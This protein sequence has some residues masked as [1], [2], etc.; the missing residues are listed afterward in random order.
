MGN[1]DEAVPRVVVGVSGGPR[2]VATVRA[3]FGEAWRRGCQLHLVHVWEPGGDRVAPYAVPGPRPSLTGRCSEERLLNATE[4]AAVRLPGVACTVEVAT[5]LP[6]RVLID[7]AYGAD[8]L[9][10]GGRASDPAPET[11]ATIGP[12]LRSIL[13]HAPCPV[14]VVGQD[15]RVTSSSASG[16]SPVAVERK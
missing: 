3:A 13:L 16:T 7:R 1:I 6:P 9:V 4:A 10:L 15:Q 14:L 12:V 11:G 2:S 8:L 5:G